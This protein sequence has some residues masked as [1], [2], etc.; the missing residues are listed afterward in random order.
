[1]TAERKVPS[2]TLLDMIE[3]VQKID[4]SVTLIQVMYKDGTSAIV[5]ENHM[6]GSCDRPEAAG[7]EA[8]RSKIRIPS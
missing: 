5:A 4:S 3:A 6:V 7:L 1:M 2:K 8:P